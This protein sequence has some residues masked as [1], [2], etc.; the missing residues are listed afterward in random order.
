MRQIYLDFNATTPIAPSVAEAMQPFIAVHFGNPSSGHSLG[1]A[2]HFAVDDARQK[3]ANLLGAEPDEIVF[4][5]GGSE[6]NNLALKGLLGGESN[7][8]HHFVI[9][10]IEHPA[11][12]VPAQFLAKLGHR[13]SIAACDHAGVVSAKE[14]AR[15]LRDDTRL[16]SVMHANNETGVIQPIREI[17]KLCRD[18]GVLFHTD[19]AQ[20]VGKIPVSVPTLGVDLLTLAGHKLYAPKG[21]GVLYVK[22]G[23]QLTPLIH[24]ADHEFGMRAGTENV[25]YI[26]G[27]GKAAELAARGHEETANRLAGLRDRLQTRLREVVGDGLTVHSLDAQRLPNTLCVSFPNVSGPALLEQVPEICAS[28]GAACHSGQ[29]AGS[30]TLQAMQVDAEVARG[31]V[32]LS[33]GW[34]TSTDDVDRACSQLSEAWQILRKACSPP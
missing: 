11:V 4:T 14:V 15:H 1:R 21:I 6:S 8:R 16:V 20:S 7:R 19:A 18:R 33:L 34:P 31:A 30:A 23:V 3:L 32:R 25:P 26:V 22:R 12:S 10:A 29:A 13:V 9:S 17:T 27:L 28:T 24:G 5:G 2:A